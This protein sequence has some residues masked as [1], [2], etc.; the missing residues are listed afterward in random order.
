VVLRLPARGCHLAEKAGGVEFTADDEHLVRALAVAAAAAITNATLLHESRR[1]HTWQT[2]MVDVSTQLLAGTD[3]DDVLQQLVQHACHTLAGLGAAVCVP[4]GD[5]LLLRVAVTQGSCRVTS[6]SVN[7]WGW[8]IQGWC[9]RFPPSPLRDSSWRWPR[10]I[11]YEPT[12]QV[13]LEGLP[14]SPRRPPG[15]RTRRVSVKT[16][17]SVLPSQHTDP[18]RARAAAAYVRIFRRVSAG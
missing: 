9:T 14:V 5:P 15:L 2:A 3:S 16:A 12:Q 8:T 18:H 1:R 17:P 7:S 6:S 13:E 10:R 4:T 11:T